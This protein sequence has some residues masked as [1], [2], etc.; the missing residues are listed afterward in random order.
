MKFSEAVLLIDD[1]FEG[2]YSEKLI[3]SKSLDIWVVKSKYGLCKCTH[4]WPQPYTPTDE[5]ME[6][7]DWELSN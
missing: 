2:D 4:D 5:D 3:K 6:V 7:E 1:D